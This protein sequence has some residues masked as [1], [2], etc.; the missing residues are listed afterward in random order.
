MAAAT[1]LLGILAGC[2]GPRGGSGHSGRDGPE[3][4]PPSGLMQV[5]DAVPRIEGVRSGGANKPYTVL[6][7]SYTPL[8]SDAPYDESGLASWYGRKF[9]GQ[10]TASGERYDMYAMTAAHTTLPIPSY[11]RVRNPANGREVVVRINDRGPFHDGRVIDLSYTAAL[12]LGVLRGVAP[13]EVHRITNEEIRAGTWQRD[14]GA[15]AYAQA[16]G[17]STGA[18]AGAGAGADLRSQRISA[19][20]VEPVSYKPEAASTAGAAPVAPPLLPAPSA[21]IATDDSAAPTDSGWKVPITVR[22][23][24]LTPPPIAVAPAPV[25]PPSPVPGAAVYAG[26]ATAPAS[27]AATVETI[28][29]RPV[30][31]DLSDYAARHPVIA[32]PLPPMRSLESS[33]TG[34]PTNQ[35]PAPGQQQRT[36]EGD[37]APAGPL[38]TG[39]S[40]WLQLGAF[41]RPEGAEQVRRN[42]EPSART[43]A[44]HVEI[45]DSQGLHRVQIGPFASR[46]A[47]ANAAASLRN[48]SSLPNPVIVER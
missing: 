30:M 47:A 36:S 29:V 44:S 18:G 48:S 39:G 45:F 4:N 27:T 11:A 37:I 6:G 7:R 9:Q 22:G 34:T 31:P 8:R 23:M 16:S 20:S 24:P 15:T 2:A 25:P 32:T 28:P 19:V 12:R 46:D 13:V 33:Q 17:S 5:P 26:E 43:I 38:T 14:G 35:A 40:Y 41:G 3:A 42:A 21:A 10:P 1:L